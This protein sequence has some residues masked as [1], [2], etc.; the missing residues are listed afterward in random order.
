MLKKG[1]IGKTG[2]SHLFLNVSI[3]PEIVERFVSIHI[4]NWHILG[5]YD[6]EV[7]ERWVYIIQYNLPPMQRCQ[8]Q[9]RSDS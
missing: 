2:K 5:T 7:T 1:P 9:P 8:Q 6:S 4:H 3:K